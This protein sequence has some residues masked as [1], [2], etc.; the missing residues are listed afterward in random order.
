MASVDVHFF[1]TACANAT[2]WAEEL[3]ILKPE[4]AADLDAFI[5]AL[6]EAKDLRNMLEHDN[7][8]LK[9]KGHKQKDYLK[10]TKVNR[11]KLSITGIPPHCIVKSDEGICI[12]GRLPFLD[13]VRAALVLQEK[14]K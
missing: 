14:M 6:R 13:A 9:G 10:D 11:G 7:E 1:V 2:K 8:Y 4:I 12:G 5:C 3:K